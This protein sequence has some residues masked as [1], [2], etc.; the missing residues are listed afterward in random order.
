M[1]KEQI[2]NAET[3]PV[4]VSEDVAFAVMRD[5]SI[6]S[7]FFKLHTFEVMLVAGGACKNPDD[8]GED[9]FLRLCLFF[10]SVSDAIRQRIERNKNTQE[11]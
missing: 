7:N 6:M 10:F 9:E 2:L 5:G 1:E 8:L 3:T 4:L 11:K